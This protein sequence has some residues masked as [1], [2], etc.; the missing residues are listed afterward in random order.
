[1]TKR[2][3]LVCLFFV[4]SLVVLP[5]ADYVFDSYQLQVDVR[6]DNSYAVQEHIAVN[7]FSPRHGIYREIPVLFGRQRVQLSNLEANVPIIKD[8]VS[9]GYAT[10][11]LGAEDRTVVGQQNYQIAY[12]YAIGD[13]RNDAYDEF[14]YNLVG[15][16]WQAPIET[17]FFTVNFP[18]PIDP[19]MVFLTGGT[20]GS[21]A[22]RG[23]FSI[24]ADG[25]T[26][27]GEARALNPGEA[28]TLRVQMEQGYF[29]EVQPFRDYTVPASILALL[30]ALFV[31]VHATLI[32][33]RYGREAL[34]IPVVRFEP[35]EDLSPMQ[36]GYLADGVV[37]NKDLTSMIFY[38]ADQGCLTITELDKKE[39]SF[40][41][42]K[43]LD[44]I[45]AHE[46]H[47]FAALFACGDG[48]QVTL[49]QL[50]KSS[51]SKDL[52]KAKTEVMRY[53]SGDRGLKD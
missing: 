7:F 14:Y 44:T 37:D 22:E 4:F 24:S 35:P 1:M 25:R 23:N 15:V 19:S 46:K 41:K 49:K 34:F 8:S 47:L 21:T 43:D 5:A 50:E 31:A 9:S 51:F 30:V 39:F 10:F 40:T 16:G 27:S 38:W 32:F 3:V 13:D 18:K 29:S 45:K 26:I 20:Y 33:R 53:F 52:Q 36:V 17:V 48:T 42:L 2:P 6:L 12:D 11:R 28:L